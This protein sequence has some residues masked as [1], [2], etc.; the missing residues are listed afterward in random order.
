M[1]LSVFTSYLPN[2]INLEIGGC[3]NVYVSDEVKG[4]NEIWKQVKPHV[5]QFEETTIRVFPNN[6]YTVRTPTSKISKKGFPDKQFSAIGNLIVDIQAFRKNASFSPQEVKDFEESQQRKVQEKREKKLK[7]KEKKAQKKLKKSEK[8]EKSYYVV[9]SFNS[10][11]SNSTLDA[12]SFKAVSENI[13][14]ANVQNL[15]FTLK[16]GTFWSIHDSNQ[17]SQTITLNG[18][19]LSGF[20]FIPYKIDV[21]L[22][23][24]FGK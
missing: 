1:Q 11:N 24:P 21:S 7:K 16:K 10:S 4:T 3:Q 20:L 12:N 6:T 18:N 15:T 22:L 14:V 19:I 13:W 8:K 9:S 23:P 5:W 17:N 2:G